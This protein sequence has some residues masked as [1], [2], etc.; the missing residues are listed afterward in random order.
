VNESLCVGVAFAAAQIWE[1]V[2]W[3]SDAAHFLEMVAPRATK[4]IAQAFGTVFWASEDFVDDD[5][6]RWLLRTIAAFPDVLTASMVHDLVVHLAKLCKYEQELVLQITQEIVKRFGSDVGNISTELYGSGVGLVNIA[7]TLQ[8]F[9]NTRTAGL[10][11]L[12][13]LL[14]LGVGEA[15]NLLRDI[16]IRPSGRLS[17]SLERP[18]RRRRRK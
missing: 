17:Q 8:R 11:L 5:N 4:R 7:M 16:D 14:K 10:T 13:E 12:E 18:R 6:T 2:P 1:E 15:F 3:R 9:S